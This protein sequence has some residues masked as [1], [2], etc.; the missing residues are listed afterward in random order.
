MVVISSGHGLHVPGARGIIDEVMEARRTVDHVAAAL[1]ALN[2]PVFAFH[3]ETARNA[4]DNLNAVIR[5]HNGHKRALDISVH[6]NSFSPVSD[7]V[8][9]SGFR[10][11]DRAVGVEVLY[12]TGNSHTKGLAGRVAANIAKASGLQL[13]HPATSGAKPRD[14]LG[15]LRHTTAPAI[16][17]EVCFVNSSVDVQLYR[18]NFEDICQAIAATINTG[19]ETII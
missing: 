15:F 18:D 8:Q 12:F 3:E 4:R 13:R 5:H 17:L 9:Q 11:V 1:V 10:Q 19:L 14:N 6:F 16:L 7:F 2:C